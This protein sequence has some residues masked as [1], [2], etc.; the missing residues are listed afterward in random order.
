MPSAD[1]WKEFEKCYDIS[2]GLI[3]ELNKSL[4]ELDKLV[5]RAPPRPP[6]SLSL[7]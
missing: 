2:L 1:Q 3:G 4:E 7:L 5:V 6:F